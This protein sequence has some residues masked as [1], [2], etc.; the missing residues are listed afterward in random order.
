MLGIAGVAIIPKRN[1]NALLR[2]A[3]LY[4]ELDLDAILGLLVFVHKTLFYRLPDVFLRRVVPEFP[5]D[6][7]AY[8]PVGNRYDFCFRHCLSLLW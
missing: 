1:V 7:I 3:D 6:V 5:V 2:I 4:G 8:L